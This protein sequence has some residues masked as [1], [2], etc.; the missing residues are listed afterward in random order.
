[1]LW[2]PLIAHPMPEFVANGLLQPSRFRKARCR[3]KARIAFLELRSGGSDHMN[4]DIDVAVQRIM[5]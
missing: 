4:G 1:M 2:L 3:C 5:P